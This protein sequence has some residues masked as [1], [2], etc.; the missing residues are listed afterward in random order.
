MHGTN[1]DP[2]I[3][4]LAVRNMFDIIEKTKNRE[5]LIRV[6]YLEIYNEVIRDL[7]DPTKTN[8][9]IHETVKREIFVGG[10]SEQ[11]VFSAK[12]VEQLLER[13]DRNRHI[14]GTNMN[15][16]SSRSHTIFRIIIESRERLEPGD[17]DDKDSQMMGSSFADD[18]N[19]GFTG[20]VKVSC[21]NLVD[22]AG[23]ERVGQT[24]AEG[25]RLKEGAHINKS[26]LALGTVISRLSEEGGDCGHVPYRD[27]KLTRILQTSLGGNART[28]IICTITPAAAYSD[29]TLSTLKFASR[30]KTITNTP[31]I[32]E[33]LRGDALLRRLKRAKELE[34]EVGRMRSIAEMK[35]QVEERNKSLLKN[36]WKSEQE[37][38][39]LERE[40][41]DRKNLIFFGHMRADASA[42]AP[43]DE[44]GG[45]EIRRQTWF[46]GIQTSGQPVRSALRTG[47]A[48]QGLVAPAIPENHADSRK[49]KGRLS[50]VTLR[51]STQPMDDEF[52]LD[53][54]V[55]D[56]QHISFLEDQLEKL[57]G[58]SDEQQ[59]ALVRFVDEYTGLLCVLNEL[60]E[61]EVVPATPPKAASASSHGRDSDGGPAHLPEITKLRRR[62]RYMLHS[63]D[64]KREQIDNMRRERPEAQFLELE[65]E[66][67]RQASQEFEA[68][69]R[70]KTQKTRE[71]ESTLSS[72]YAEV[73][74]LREALARKDEEA[75]ALANDAK[76][77]TARLMEQQKV[78]EADRDATAQQVA[79]L[80]S[81]VE[82]VNGREQVWVKKN[83]ELESI[84][85]TR[86]EE[87]QVQL[88]SAQSEHEEERLRT[89][90]LLR[91]LQAQNSALQQQHASK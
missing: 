24:G 59:K 17:D 52:E 48:E 8:L 66:A 73:K 15:E 55:A 90:Q 69:L 84:Y 60:A 6:S 11:I 54:I 26:L 1:T 23:S 40:L 9:K 75:V 57:R 28:A 21:L 65:L 58:E 74:E 77:L 56:K 68:T 35:I 85:R 42:S 33:E 22:L 53:R 14:G 47:V 50:N 36:L 89:E 39:R 30:A 79:T 86:I 78:H 62:L 4:K 72:A 3:I 43:S 38:L 45:R 44:T 80:R 49:Q 19:G 88:R 61:A 10:L 41:E 91:E 7:L 31:E 20:A 76:A 46:P 70:Q 18:E 16:R 81:K 71:L 34:D 82:E 25:Q 87:L 5:F 67:A 27:S 63:L 64:A 29:E 32:N 83:E 2:G 12:E 37:R 51:D 13:G